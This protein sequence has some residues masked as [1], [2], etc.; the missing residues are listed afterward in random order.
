[1]SAVLSESHTLQPP[2]P[3]PA[4]KQIISVRYVHQKA[5][6]SY[7]D[8]SN[9]LCVDHETNLE[10][11]MFSTLLVTQIACDIIPTVL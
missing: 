9:L 10:A 1:M 4:S 11:I 5:N 3:I 8:I 6:P 2:M 7:S